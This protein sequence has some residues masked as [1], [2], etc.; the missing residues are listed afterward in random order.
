MG[1]TQAAGGETSYGDGFNANGGGVYALDWTSDHINVWFW[2]RGSQPSDLSESPDPAGWGKP[3]ASFVGRGEF[4]SAVTCEIDSH[5]RNQAI[6]FDTT[7]C[8]QL[9]K[10]FTLRLI[11]INLS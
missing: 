4:D 11:R 7:F 2:P 5:F 9:L 10:A 3:T 6:V 8:G 1:C